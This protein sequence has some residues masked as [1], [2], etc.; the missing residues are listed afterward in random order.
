MLSHDHIDIHLIW[1]FFYWL[2]LHLFLV[3]SLF[4]FHQS[5]RWKASLDWI[6]IDCRSGCKSLGPPTHLVNLSIY[7]IFTLKLCLFSLPVGLKSFSV[8]LQGCGMYSQSTTQKWRRN[9]REPR[10]MST[11]FLGTQ[12]ENHQ[13][14]TLGCSISTVFRET[15]YTKEIVWKFLRKT[16]LDSVWMSSFCLFPG[17][18]LME[19]PKE[20]NT[21]LKCR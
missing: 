11:F 15:F 14:F 18:R 6:S 12:L 16:F 3:L 8:R 9:N 1:H 2:P 4:W 20:T 19:L 5:Q 7:D 13:K 17:K 21:F 10:N